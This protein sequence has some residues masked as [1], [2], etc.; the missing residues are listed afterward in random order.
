MSWAIH[1]H[2]EVAAWLADLSGPSAENV[3]AAID[4]LA[5]DGPSLG[6]PLVDTIKGSRHNNMKELRART[7]RI[8]FVFDP[9]RQA[10]L[11][12][13]GDRRGEWSRWYRKAVPLA[14]DRYDEWL[15]AT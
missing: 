9:R 15:S 12:V 10:V 2:P 14:D 1:Q 3:T 11:L 13:A 7:V 5:D 4:R 8:L 6:R